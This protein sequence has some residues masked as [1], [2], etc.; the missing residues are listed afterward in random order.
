MTPAQELSFLKDQAQ[1]IR[2][3]LGQIES[4]IQEMERE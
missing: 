3:Q 2:N 1:T 4:R